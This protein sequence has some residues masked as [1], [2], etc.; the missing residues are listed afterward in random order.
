M[1]FIKP[2]QQFQKLSKDG[3]FDNEE[4][5]AKWMFN[6]GIPEYT[7]ILWALQNFVKEDKVFVD[8]GAHIGTWSWTIAQY[9]KMTYTFEC[10]P[11]VYNCLCANIFLKELS[12]KIK[13]Y[14]YGISNQEDILTYY[15]RSK[16]GGGNGF[17]M[18][19]ND[20]NIESLSI[21]TKKLDDFKILDIGLIKI[22]VEGHELEVLQGSVETLIQNNYP[23]IIFESWFPKSQEKEKLRKEL[24]S[25]LD[26]LGYSIVP[27]T[28]TQEIFLAEKK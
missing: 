6:E 19:E 18:L 24:F 1:Y 3:F 17:T 20:D 23:P 15:I 26:F 14:P 12:H 9:S 22:D 4:N 10:N 21:Q 28:G 25:F 2:K 27:L 7:Y 8:I 5:V 11:E 13:A 16:D